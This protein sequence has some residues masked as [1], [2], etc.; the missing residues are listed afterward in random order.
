MD[1]VRAPERLNGRGDDW[2]PIVFGTSSVG[3]ARLQDLVNSHVPWNHFENCCSKVHNLLC[4]Y[5][6]TLV[7]NCLM[8]RAWGMCCRI[9][10][11]LVPA[12]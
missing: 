11:T 5:S 10:A 3:H 12:H 9:Q 6:I 8:E 1:R 7:W 2:P 4:F